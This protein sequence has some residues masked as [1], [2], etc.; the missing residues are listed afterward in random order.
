[1]DIERVILPLKEIPRQWYNVLPDMPEKLPPPLNPATGK[2]LGPADLLPI[3]P[4]SLIEQEMTDKR[5]IDIPPEILDIYQ[6]WR[7]TPL[8]RAI[9]LRRP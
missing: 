7:P 6:I 3:F 4:M 2:P 8:Q 5:W 1:M 9:S